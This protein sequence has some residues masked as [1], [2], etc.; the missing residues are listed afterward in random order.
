MNPLSQLP[1]SSSVRFSLS[2]VDALKIFRVYLMAAAGVLLMQLVPAM[3]NFTTWTAFLHAFT[4]P[5]Y[6][7][8][9]SVPLAEAIRRFITGG[10]PRDPLPVSI[11]TP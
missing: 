5:P 11:T 10:T 1:A 6:M 9:L 7:Q 2:Q 4:F 3:Q 8:A